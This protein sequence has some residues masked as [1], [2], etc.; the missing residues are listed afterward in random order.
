[1]L[2]LSLGLMAALLWSVHDLLARKLAPGA[3]LLPIILMVLAAGCVVLVLPALIFGD[4]QAVTGRALWL[5][6]AAGLTF[7]LAIGT[8]YRAFSMA[9][10]RIVSPI[11]GAYPMLSLLIAALQGRAVTGAD[12]LAVCAVVLGIA[13]VSATAET[14]ESGGSGLPVAAMAWSFASACGFALTFALGQEAARQGSEL[15]TILVTRLTATVLIAALFL[16][17][18][19]ETTALKGR[20][21]VL[22]GMGAM[23]A[24]G[25]SLVTASGSLP[26]AEYAAVASSL[27]GVGT[28]LLAARFLNEHLR[29]VQWAGVVTVF[30]GIATLGLQG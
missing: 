12:W 15:P 16:W 1:M 21:W 8:L 4:W 11:I 20:W 19:P 17:R 22:A 5:A 2:A 9:P 23:D 24:L 18:R 27:F 25:L 26:Q 6:L 7:S 14:A 10:A 29:P 28:I 3:A 30:A 13:I